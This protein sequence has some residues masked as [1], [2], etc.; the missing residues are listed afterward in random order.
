M[1]SEVRLN[2][3][4]ETMNG[5][6]VEKEQI[7]GSRMEGACGGR[8]MKEE[9]MMMEEQRGDGRDMV[10]LS[11]TRSKISEHLLSDEWQHKHL[12]NPL[13]IIIRRYFIH[14]VGCYDTRN[15]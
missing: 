5:W 13:Y 1:E 4:Q 10:V 15:T 8:L 9:V 3:M 11:D 6:R 14:L 2:S 7:V 12:G